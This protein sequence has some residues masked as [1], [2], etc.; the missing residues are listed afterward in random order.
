MLTVRSL[1]NVR[2]PVDPNEP[3][4]RVF[5]EIRD[6]GI[7]DLVID[8]RACRTGVAGSIE[9]DAATEAAWVLAS[10]L[11]DAPFDVAG[12]GPGPGRATVLARDVSDWVDEGFAVQT[13]PLPSRPQGR[14]RPGTSKANATQR[15]V[16]PHPDRPRGDLT[17]LIGPATSGPTVAMLARVAEQGRIRFVGEPSGTLVGS[18]D[19]LA[20][21]PVV[22]V[23]LPESGIRLTL[24]HGESEP[25]GGWGTTQALEPDLRV[26]P[27]LDDFQSGRD[28]VLAAA[29]AR[30]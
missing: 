5:R 30:D 6:A 23:T 16:V 25:T 28:P 20:G 21:T 2:R 9:A 22:R 11:A 14:S 24:P 1:T 17:A 4:C 7:D 13:N 3:F 26:V 10:Y 18:H 29:L 15:R 27:T 12:S 19:A 8:L